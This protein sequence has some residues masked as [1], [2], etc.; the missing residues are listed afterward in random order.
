MVMA[1]PRTYSTLQTTDPYP[2]EIPPPAETDMVPSVP[3]EEKGK[4]VGDIQDEINIIQDTVNQKFDD[5]EKE[6]SHRRPEEWEKKSLDEDIEKDILWRLKWREKE[7]EMQQKYAE[8]GTQK[9]QE[10]DKS[11]NQ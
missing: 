6:T 5:F 10:R 4:L 8:K 11:H 2:L 9:Q 3:S 7:K 1:T